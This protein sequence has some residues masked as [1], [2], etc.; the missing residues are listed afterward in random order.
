MSVSATNTTTSTAAISKLKF[1]FTLTKDQV[2]AVE[3]WIKN[4]FRGTVLYST[5][6][7]KTEIA[8]ECAKRVASIIANISSTTPS[9]SNSQNTTFNILLLVPRITLIEQNIK[10]LISYD[11]PRENIGSYFGE[12]KEVREI[13]VATYQS[14]IRNL[15][16]IRKS[17]MVIFDEIHLVSDSAKVFRNIFDT[18]LEDHQK[19]ILGLTATLDEAD[20][21]KYN[22]ILT[23]LPPVKRYQIKT[24]VSDKRL[25]KPIV[26]PV[27]VSLTE[28]EQEEYDTYSSKIK[29]ISNRFK[30]YDAQS[31]T[32]LLKKGGFV[33]GM[34]KAWFSNVRKR[35]LLLSCTENKLLAA[36]NLITKK[37]PNERIMVFS[38]TIDSINKLKNILELYGTKSK[39]IDSKTSAN[40]RQ[41]ILDQWGKDFYPLLSVH[42]LEIGFDIPQ[43]RIEIIL[44]TTSNMN[45]VVQRIGRVIRKHEGKDLA[46]IYVIYISDTKDDDILQVMRKA[47]TTT[48]TTEGIIIDSIE[49][50]ERK[51]DSS[52]NNKMKSV[53]PA[54]KRRLENAYRIIE[55]S[56]IE[57]MIIELKDCGSDTTS[58]GS[59]S[60]SEE[61]NN[62]QNILEKNN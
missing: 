17:N 54:E 8:F 59:N 45:Q 61:S 14:T 32:V 27:K 51:R 34:A 40:K 62:N 28:K 16:I 55:S 13:T 48:T 25:A 19:A 7:G 60:S 23:L 4:D 20:L 38:E 29:K 58:G 6:T 49:D 36:I 11:I 24:A 3:A 39:V 10:R 42:T 37:F 9:S 50:K 5:G 56:L 1:P 44:A 53:K 35:K 43:V 30:K 15:D 47:I 21:D 26:I 52:I 57:P 33:S 31:M 46:L 22:T 12:R 41:K 18:V 2:E